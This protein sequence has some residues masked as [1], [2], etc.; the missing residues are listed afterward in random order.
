MARTGIPVGGG[1]T[2]TFNPTL[3]PL[4]A[5]SGNLTKLGQIYSNDIDPNAI[6]G[7]ATYAGQASDVL[8]TAGMMNKWGLWVRPFGVFED[9]DT[10]DGTAGYNYNTAGFSAGVDFRFSKNFIA[11]VSLGYASSRVKYDDAGGSSGDVQSFSAG[12]YGSYFTPRWFIEFSLAYARNTFDMK[13]Q[14]VFPGANRQA[15]SNYSGYAV[16]ALLGGGYDF[17][18]GRGWALG[19]VG[20]LEYVYQKADGFTETGALNLTVGSQG[21][22]SFR[23]ALGIR[24]R[25]MVT[26]DKTKF[27]FSLSALWVHEFA[28]DS[29]G[30][31]S[32]MAG[33]PATRFTV[34]TPDP[35][36][37]AIRL[38]LGV[39]A[40][41]SDRVALFVHYQPE[42]RANNQTHTVSGGIRIEF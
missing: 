33:N 1:N 29:R 24:V 14:I 5:Y 34:N 28:N 17:D 7:L 26:V 27:T 8:R 39:T 15:T 40:R 13:R 38:G 35:A 16:T 20:S 30:I 31:S 25:R 3:G 10:V 11:G 22:T 36:R 6:T 18:L 4:L 42:F 32:T 37:D 23:A 19:P 41:M 12:V 2:A 21:A 9:Q